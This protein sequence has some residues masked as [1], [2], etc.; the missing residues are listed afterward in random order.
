MIIKLDLLLYSSDRCNGSTD[1]NESD[2]K[3]NYNSVGYQ[4]LLTPC[5]I[6]NVSF[7]NT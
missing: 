2:C 5:Q 1:A 3:N 7:C 6:L 4:L